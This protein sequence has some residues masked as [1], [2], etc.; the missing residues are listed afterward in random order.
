M[1]WL[2]RAVSGLNDLQDQVKDS[3]TG[4]GNQD[5][6]NKQLS[7]SISQE[8]IDLL[9]TLQMS[10]KNGEVI[11]EITIRQKAELL[12]AKRKELVSSYDLQIKASQKIY[13]KL[14]SKKYTSIS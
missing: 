6:Q 3:L 13:E 5:L 8:E 2:E 11:D 4:I 14:G 9:E 10:I 1:S 12:I 7:D